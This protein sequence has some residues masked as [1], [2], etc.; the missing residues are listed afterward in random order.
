MCP[1]VRNLP[2][3]VTGVRSRAS[4]IKSSACL[5]SSF[6]G[7]KGVCQALSL[8]WYVTKDGGSRESVAL[9]CILHCGL[10]RG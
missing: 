9:H 2:L 1:A 6:Y 5:P 3:S 10:G 4:H 8:S 7:G